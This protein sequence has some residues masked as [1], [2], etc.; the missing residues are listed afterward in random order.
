MQAD[1]CDS[2]RDLIRRD[3]TPLLVGSSVGRT[4]RAEKCFGV[5]AFGFRLPVE[6]GRSR[7]IGYTCIPGLEKTAP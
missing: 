2:Q 3:G 4:Y 6:D 5:S 1:P 7:F